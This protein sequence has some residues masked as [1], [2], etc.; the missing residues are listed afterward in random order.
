[1]I[2]ENGRVYEGM[3]LKDFREGM[4]FEQFSNGNKYQ[5]NFV[6]GK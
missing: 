4:G 2:Y 1:M 6:R 3:W 5:G